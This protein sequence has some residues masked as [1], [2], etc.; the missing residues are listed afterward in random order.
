MCISSLIFFFRFILLRLWRYRRDGGPEVTQ[1]TFKSSVVAPSNGQVG[2]EDM[3][4]WAN[5][6]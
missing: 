3:R 1:E 4:L 5:V 6:I 2:V